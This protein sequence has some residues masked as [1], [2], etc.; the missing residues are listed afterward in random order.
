[1]K[2]TLL[3]IA[4]LL[5]ATAGMAQTLVGGTPA[6]PAEAFGK[7]AE[8]STPAQGIRTQAR[9]IYTLDASATALPRK[10]ARRKLEGITLE[11]GQYILGNSLSDEYYNYGSIPYLGD[12]LV[13]SII[14]KESYEKL[15]N[16]KALG[17]RFCIPEAVTIKA[18]TLF[19]SNIEQQYIQRPTKPCK[20]GWNYVQFATPQS[21]DPAGCLIS[22][23][24]VQTASNYGI[25][26]W[27]DKAPGGLY[28]YAFNSDRGEYTWLNASNQAGAAC[29]QLV[30]EADVPDY[31]VNC[32]EALCN[33]VAMSSE[34]SAIIYMQ[35]NSQKQINS[36]DYDITIDGQT[37]STHR[38]FSEPVPAG[39]DQNFG[40]EVSFPTPAKAAD[41]YDVKF[42]VKKANGVDIT[43]MPIS[44]KMNV[45]TRLVPRQTVIEEFTGTACGNCPR[46]YA[47]MEYIKEAYEGRAYVIAVHQY[48]NTDPMYCA[49]YNDPGWAGAP[50]C[51]VDRKLTTDP[52]FGKGYGIYAVVDDC[53]AEAPRVDI[54]LTAAFTDENQTKVKATANLEFLGEAKGYSIAYVLT[55]DSLRGTTSAWRQDNYYTDRTPEVAGATDI[56]PLMA[57]FCQGGEWCQSKVMLTYNDVALTSSWT[58]QG[59]NQATKLT[60]TIAAGKTLTNSYTL[61]LPTA[62]ALMQAVKKDQLFVTALVLDKE[63]KVANAQRC[64]VQSPV[65]IDGPA[66][67]TAGH[68]DAPAYDL[69]GRRINAGARG[70]LIQGGRKIIVR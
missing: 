47:G 37:H 45:F 64:R 55:A 23:T 18:V 66:V 43:S 26:N 35:S 5:C 14:Y 54:G 11:P 25:C 13:G 62:A 16:V 68:S 17:I 9:N 51:C 67:Q 12:A 24:Y 8:A 42:Q 38:T 63:G 1:M 28:V 61:T 36:L 49:R 19:D 58:E 10:E 4:A 59:A 44:F 15:K 30:V 53:R 46:G 56:M 39:I 32:T 69:Q 52:Y 27:P 2:K 40:L 29:I 60:S 50:T 6:H 3:L 33:H 48:N 41:N 34:G 57:K 7:S 31:E 22:Y 21:I 20:K 65:G 70:L